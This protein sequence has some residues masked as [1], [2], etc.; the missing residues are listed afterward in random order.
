MILWL[1]LLTSILFASLNSVLLHRLPAKSDLFVFNM[2]A[3]VL[4]IGI[5]FALNGFSL[6]LSPEIILWGILY[7]VTQEL[8]MFF[9]AQAMKNGSVSIT[10]LIGNC[11]LILSTSVGVIVW[12]E[13]VSVMQ[14]V[15]IALLLAA[16]FLCTYKKSEKK[17][18]SSKL[19]LIYCLFFFTFAAGVGI[20]FKFFSKTSGGE[21]AGDMMIVAAMTMLIFSGIKIAIR[22]LMQK[23][24]GE[25]PCYSKA[26]FVIAVLS[27]IL[28]CG[29]NRLNI[30]LAGLFDSVIFYPSFN[31]GVILLSAILSVI[32]LRERLSKRQTIGLVLGVLA[33]VTVGIF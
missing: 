26:F 13:S 9:K 33:V 2:T 28:S 5:L 22:R 1:L 27:G 8:F 23:G 4:W 30:S 10:T 11:S 6:T 14:I 19:W 3:S 32:F 18:S 17:E 29:Y 7:G 12:K 25:K 24:K 21:G 16:F 20:I 31:G 15:G